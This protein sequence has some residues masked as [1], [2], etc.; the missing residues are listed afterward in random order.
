M[1]LTLANRITILRIF[2]VPFFILSILYYIISVAKGEPSVPLRWIGLALFLGVFL[3]D[4]VDGY[5]ARARREITSLG[6][7]LDP[8][9]DKAALISALILLSGHGAEKAFDPHLPVWFTLAAISRD[10][11]LVTGTLIIHGVAGGVHVQPRILGKITT[12]LQGVSILWVLIGLPAAAL[13][14]ILYA[15][16]A[17]TGASAV[18]YLLDGVRQLER[19]R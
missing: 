1:P 17:F 18:Q 6:T 2:T 13:P 3:L 8:I 15:A 9:A 14:W 7:L 10:A 4:A 19:E 11:I 16:V 12:F 5:L